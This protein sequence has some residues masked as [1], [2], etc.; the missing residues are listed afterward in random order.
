M[1]ADACLQ[2]SRQCT[3]PAGPLNRPAVRTKRPCMPHLLSV[4]AAVSC[5][6]SPGWGSKS[7]SLNQPTRPRGHSHGTSKSSHRGRDDVALHGDCGSFQDAVSQLAGPRTA[8]VPGDGAIC[9]KKVAEKMVRG[10]SHPPSS[11]LFTL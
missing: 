2:A 1:D 11:F 6:S 3:Q 7:R 8:L 9:G 10:S 4:S 5:T